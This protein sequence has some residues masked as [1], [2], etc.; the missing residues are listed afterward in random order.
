M[1]NADKG[2]LKPE[3]GACPSLA[4]FSLCQLFSPSLRSIHNTATGRS[5]EVSRQNG[6]I[7]LGRK[8]ESAKAL[9]HS[10][11]RQRSHQERS[12]PPR[13]CKG[14]R[15]A[16]RLLKAKHLLHWWVHVGYGK[17]V[18]KQKNRKGEAENYLEKTGNYTERQEQ[19]TSDAI[20]S[21]ST[22]VLW[23]FDVWTGKGDFSYARTTL[24]NDHEP[25]PLHPLFA[26]SGPRNA[27]QVFLHDQ[28][29]YFA[30]EGFVDASLEEQL[31]F[32][33]SFAA[34][35]VHELT[36]CFAA[37]RRGFLQPEEWFHIDDPDC[38]LGWSWESEAFGGVILACDQKLCP[39]G[40]LVWNTWAEE[41]GKK[42]AGGYYRQL[43]PIDW[44]AGWFREETWSGES[45][46]CVVQDDLVFW[47]RS[48][49]KVSLVH[50]S[51]AMGSKR[52][53]TALCDLE[54]D[55]DDDHDCNDKVE[56][57]SLAVPQSKRLCRRSG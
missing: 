35:I 27:C 16:S 9:A 12:L 52:P 47:E 6:S 26:A 56:E 54:E 50:N 20:D 24:L 10:R 22:L 7:M 36:H 32:S 38:E 45:L 19:L 11:T 31:R 13:P 34:T 2:T 55:S 1:N 8:P 42:Q 49:K 28:Y 48:R 39:P 53:F 25:Q 57:E 23:T 37:M 41:V 18:L 44:I 21:L 30:E 40:H 15:L 4:Y 46:L 51:R 43:V 3:P 5:C 33:F 29:R 17:R 14:L